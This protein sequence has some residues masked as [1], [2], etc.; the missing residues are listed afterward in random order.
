METL[1]AVGTEELAAFGRTLGTD[2]LLQRFL[3]SEELATQATPLPLIMRT[4]LMP[5]QDLLVVIEPSA[6]QAFVT[7]DICN[8]KKINTSEKM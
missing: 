8:R 6:L 7:G 2:V 1:V 5:E 3:V 4:F